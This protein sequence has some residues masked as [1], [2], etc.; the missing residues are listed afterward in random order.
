MES[1]THL[2]EQ[3]RNSSMS[4]VA[5]SCHHCTCATVTLYSHADVCASRIGSSVE[6]Q[7]ASSVHGYYANLI[8]NS[9]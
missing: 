3:T 1:V 2:L 7:P 4:D 9:W 8:L 5:A 6:R